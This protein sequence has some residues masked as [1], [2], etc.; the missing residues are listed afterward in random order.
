MNIYLNGI[1]A[2]DIAELG[3]SLEGR[4]PAEII[5]GV[6]ELAGREKTVFATSLGPEDQVITHILAEKGLE[7]RTFTLDT[8][9]LHEDTYELIDTTRIRYGIRIEIYF[10]DPKGVEEL[11]SDRGMNL[12]YRC[13]EDRKMCCRVLKLDPLRRALG[14]AKAWITGLRREQ[15]ATR[16]GTGALEMDEANGLIKVNPLYDWSS[17]R[18]WEYIRANNV[19]YNPLHDRGYTSI[20]CEPCTRA[21][22]SGEDRRAGR[23]WWERPDGRECGLHRKEA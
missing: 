19:P 4:A 23:W 17:D 5:A 10:P 11:V 9:R 14:D 20:G 15:S 22:R 13:V 18:P 21:V 3:K 2:A 1:G 6:A 16:E 8:G 12:F 7:I